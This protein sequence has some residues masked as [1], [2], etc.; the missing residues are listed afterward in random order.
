MLPIR[1]Q[2][3]ARLLVLHR[4]VIMLKTGIPLL[5]WLVLLA[6]V[7]EARDSQPRSISTGLTSLGIE[8]SSKGLVTSKHSTITL[9]VNIGYTAFLHSHTEELIYDEMNYVY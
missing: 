9:Q 4:A 3:P 1:L 5:A 7:I 6:I 8:A 2:L